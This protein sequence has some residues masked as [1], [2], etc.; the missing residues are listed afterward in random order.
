MVLRFIGAHFCTTLDRL[1]GRVPT[2]EA[3]IRAYREQFADENLD[4]EDRLEIAAEL[5][6]LDS[7]YCDTVILPAVLGKGGSIFWK[8]DLADIVM[9]DLVEAGVAQIDIRALPRGRTRGLGVC[10]SL[11][12]APC[13]GPQRA[14]KRT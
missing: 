2:R 13:L 6:S 7:Y 14:R 10:R 12:C 9:D 1:V 3:R 8:R 5:A 4:E 11:P